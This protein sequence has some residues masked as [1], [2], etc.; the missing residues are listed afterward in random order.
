MSEL[1]HGETYDAR[2]EVEGWSSPSFEDLGWQKT[3]VKDRPESTLVAQENEPT[4]IIET[5]KPIDVITTPKGELVL[6]MG[7]NM[8][9]WV[10]FTVHA[11][12]GTI[13]TLEHAEVLDCEGN[14]YIGN[15]RSAKQTVTY[16]CRGVEA[17]TFEPYLSFQGFRYVKVTGIPQDQLL[18]QFTG[19]VIHTDLEQ[20][21][22]FT[23][24][25]ELLNQLQHN[26]FGDKKGI[27]SI[28][29]QIAL[30]GTKDWDGRG[31]LKFLFVRLPTI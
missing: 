14:F 2:L 20:T 16:T 6:D 4:R 25:D 27:F 10:R 31:M 17:E 18:E 12:A 9:G 19:C 11:E 26:I 30:N 24:S 8:V 7:Q 5:I 3:I 15:L 22:S 1:Y 28:S 29:Q 13:V 21:G 23:C